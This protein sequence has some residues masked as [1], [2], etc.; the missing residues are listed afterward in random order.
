MVNFRPKTLKMMR[1]T[2]L[3]LLLPMLLLFSCAESLEDQEL[4]TLER[5]RTFEI[6][7]EVR[8]YDFGYL[9]ST[10]NDPNRP[11]LNVF[12][13]RIFLTTDD[14]LNQN[15]V[16]EGSS[17]VIEIALRYI[18]TDIPSEV[19]TDFSNFNPNNPRVQVQAFIG[20]DFNFNTGTALR[21]NALSQGSLTIVLNSNGSRTIFLRAN[22][23]NL[24]VEGTWSGTL[25]EAG[26]GF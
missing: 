12:D 11:Q 26:V 23:G 4:A 14:V 7:L 22:T 21:R 25:E 1:P 19:V 2:P 3:M 16:L 15:G 18:S 10:Q 20:E 6:D 9:V 8:R 17:Q 5:D 13:E 24:P